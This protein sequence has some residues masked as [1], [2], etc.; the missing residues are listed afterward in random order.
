MKSS[1]CPPSA[2]ARS[3]AAANS[4]LASAAG[5]APVGDGGEQGA[6]GGLAMAHGAPVPQ[7]ALE[8]REIGPAR[9]RGALP[10]RRLAVAVRRDPPGAVEEREIGLLFR[11]HGEQIAE[12][13]EDGRA[14]SPAVAVLDGE[15]R[16]LPQDL[17]R[18]HAGR[19]L[20]PHGLGDHEPEIVGKAV[21]EPT[22]PM[23]RRRRRGRTTA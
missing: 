13:G 18:G 6:F 21:V 2:K 11:Q 15:Q 22:A 9:E 1:E 10:S 4:R 7:P 23:A 12:R 19:E 5:G 8:G 17:P 14:D 3:V 16:R 20:S